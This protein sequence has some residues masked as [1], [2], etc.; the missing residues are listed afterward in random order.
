M[1]KCKNK[2]TMQ[3]NNSEREVVQRKNNAQKKKQKIKIKKQKNITF[4]NLKIG[5][6]FSFHTLQALQQHKCK[7][8]MKLQEG[9]STPWDFV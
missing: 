7:W 9:D 3:N 6:K 2:A 1:Q 4:H 5:S 8:R